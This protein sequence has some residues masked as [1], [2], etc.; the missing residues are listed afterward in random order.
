[1]QAMNW[2]TGSPPLQAE[3]GQFDVSRNALLMVGHGLASPALA[4]SPDAI[5]LTPAPEEWGFT[6]HGVNME[7]ILL[8]GAVTMG[9][10]LDAKDGWQMM[11]SGG[12]SLEAPCLPCQE[13]HALVRVEKPVREMIAELERWG[14]AH[15]AIIVHGDVRAELVNLAKTLGIRWRVF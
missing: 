8:P 4:A 15:H 3:W 10:F 1:M 6:G 14:V 5:T 2:L 12:E 9:H 13:I 7:F 11:I